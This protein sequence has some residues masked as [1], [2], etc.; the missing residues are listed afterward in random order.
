MNEDIEKITHEYIKGYVVYQ[1][2][3]MEGGGPPN[4]TFYNEEDAEKFIKDSM[5]DPD[6]CA[7]PAACYMTCTG[8][9]YFWNDYSDAPD[10]FLELVGEYKKQL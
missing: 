9:V 2:P 10:N 4:A 8:V 5:A 3:D 1:C 7:V 6:S